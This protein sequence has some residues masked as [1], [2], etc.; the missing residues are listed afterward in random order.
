MASPHPLPY[1]RCM[2]RMRCRAALRAVA[3]AAVGLGC[4]TGPVVPQ[5]RTAQ[6]VPEAD[7]ACRATVQDRMLARGVDQVVAKVSIAPSGKVEHVELL[8]PDL[9]PATA[10]E[11]RAAFG[12]C[13][14]AP[15]VGPDGTVAPRLATIRFR[16]T[17]REPA[18]TK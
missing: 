4:A 17:P 3:V 12:E 15:E 14:W 1:V 16:A 8:T 7:P 9:T 6:A 18:K 5:S 13:A 11:L 2:D 10:A